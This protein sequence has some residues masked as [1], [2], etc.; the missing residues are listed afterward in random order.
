LFIS[1]D[2]SAMKVL[3]DRVAVLYLGRLIEDGSADQFYRAP[4]HP[5]SAALL[6]AIPVPDPAI[7]RNRERVPL[8]GEMPDPA[9]P[10]SGC[11]FRTR[12]AFAMEVC[13]Q[14]RP[15]S[16]PLLDGG[17]VACHLQSHGPSL[18][19]RPLESLVDVN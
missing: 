15:A 17:Q 6:S 19:G 1:H 14:G 12:C 9:N 16:L 2:L 13:S 7:Q 18:S 5:Y 4:A 8:M 10:P 11:T 3:V